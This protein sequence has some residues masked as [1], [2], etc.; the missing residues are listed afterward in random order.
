MLVVCAKGCSGTDGHRDD[1]D[2]SAPTLDMM[3]VKE[4]AAPWPKTTVGNKV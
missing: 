3:V 1:E 2:D 4:E